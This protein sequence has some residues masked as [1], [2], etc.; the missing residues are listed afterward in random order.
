MSVTGATEAAVAPRG[1]HRPHHHTPKI[2]TSCICCS[3]AIRAFSVQLT[4]RQNVAQRSPVT[5]VGP[6]ARA[7]V[8]CA[9][10]L[11][12][13]PVF[14][15]ESH[16]PMDY[17]RRQ[18]GSGVARFVAISRAPAARARCMPSL[19]RLI[20]LGASSTVCCSRSINPLATEAG[21]DSARRNGGVRV[22]GADALTR[23]TRQLD[24]RRGTRQMTA[25]RSAP[26]PLRR[27]DVR[28]ARETRHA[29]R[30]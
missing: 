30:G 20:R 28:A 18:A 22:L 8:R 23:P 10:R 21:Q 15:V 13:P 25:T 26:A 19:Q 5:R 4:Q 14:M 12:D 29:P 3:T 1:R 27:P 16:S 11:S 7:H 9:L 17:G 24:G 6:H 2:G